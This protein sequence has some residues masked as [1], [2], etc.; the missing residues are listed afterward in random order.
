MPNAL[1]QLA[2]NVKT[3]TIWKTMNAKF[4]QKDK[5]AQM[6]K[7]KNY[8]QLAI[9]KTKKNKQ[10]AKPAQAINIR[11]KKEKKLV[12]LVIAEITFQVLQQTVLV[13]HVI[14]IALF[15]AKMPIIVQVAK[16]IIFY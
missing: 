11:T 14:A 9:I 1:L 10:L 5:N 3:D 7:R 2:Q 16:L 4:A 13:L 8:A 12:K 15:V 6:A